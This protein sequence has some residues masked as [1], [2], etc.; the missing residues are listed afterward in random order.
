MSNLL[1]LWSVFLG[2]VVGLLAIINPLAAA[3]TFM[4]ITEGDTE[5]RRREQALKGCLYTR[6]RAAPIPRRRK[7][8]AAWF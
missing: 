3:P 8:R 6:A 5:E 4:A 1:H 2:T 7:G